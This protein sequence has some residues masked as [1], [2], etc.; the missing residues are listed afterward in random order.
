[1]NVRDFDFDLPSDLI[2]QEPAAERT[3]AR[4]LH[5]DRQT[6]SIVHTTVAAL[7]NCLRAGDLL[8]VNDTRVFPARLIGRRVP[9]GGA[10]ECLLV[11]RVATRSGTSPCRATSSAT[12]EA[13]IASDIKRC[14][15]KAEGR[16]Q[17]RLQGYTSLL[18]SSQ[19]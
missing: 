13:T 17:R 3:S 14:L 7:A 18:H 6:G 4:L 11:R 19:A 2:A 10:V 5:L 12:T 8:V 1:M 9:S 16:S 15:H